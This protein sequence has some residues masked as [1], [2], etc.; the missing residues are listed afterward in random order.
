M[1]EEDPNPVISTNLY[2]IETPVCRHIAL[3]LEKTLVLVS[4]PDAPGDFSYKTSSSV[5]GVVVK[6]SYEK[7]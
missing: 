2:H 4:Y 3:L 6:Q 5:V 7:L 1:E